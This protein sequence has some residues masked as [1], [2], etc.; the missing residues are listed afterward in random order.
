LLK[1]LKS[2][3]SAFCFLVSSSLCRLRRRVVAG[4]LKWGRCGETE[5]KEAKVGGVCRTELKTIPDFWPEQANKPTE[6]CGL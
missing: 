3:G 5:E 2:L 6:N 4:A 1:F